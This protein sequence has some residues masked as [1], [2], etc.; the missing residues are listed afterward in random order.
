MH[1]HSLQRPQQQ[2]KFMQMCMHM[3][4]CVLMFS[5]LMRHEDVTALS[6]S[7][8]AFTSASTSTSCSSSTSISA[9]PPTHQ[10]NT[11][12]SPYTDSC[13]A[14]TSSSSSPYHAIK[15]E[16]P[17]KKKGRAVGSV[18]FGS[19]DVN[20]LLDCVEQVLPIGS[21]LWEKVENMYNDRTGNFVSKNACMCISCSN[22]YRKM[23]LYVLMYVD[24]TILH[25]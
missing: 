24:V 10:Y 22:R 14:S 5:A 3:I 25:V 17:P 21:D 4:A 6:A 9:P 20:R 16:Y 11:R 7:S 15:Q 13:V 12:A 1:K 23:L 8:T 18:N 2:Q 19:A